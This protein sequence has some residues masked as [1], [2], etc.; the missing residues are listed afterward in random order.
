[1]SEQ[2]SLDWFRNRCG[3]WNGSEVAALM[4]SGRSKDKIFG[5]TAVT[6]IIKVLAERNINPK[7]MDDDVLFQ[8]YL[9]LETFSNKFT[10]HGNE[11]EDLARKQFAKHK[12]VDIMEVGSCECEDAPT[13]HASP[14]GLYYEDGEL[15]VLEI[16]CPKAS[17]FFEYAT[18][19][20]DWESLKKVNAKYY[21]QL[22]AEMVCTGATKASF[23]VFNTYMAKPMHIVEL[24][25]NQEAIDQLIER[26]RLAEEFISE[27]ENG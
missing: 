20:K 27:I 25:R 24:K 15:A 13:L 6:Y 22:N 18:Y 10:D 14:D 4:V 16:K 17:T 23:V 3:C 7:V 2:K 21:W 26:V 11:M 19:I 9:D 1:M 5:D 12:L 8:Q